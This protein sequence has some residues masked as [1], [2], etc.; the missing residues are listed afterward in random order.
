MSTPQ[1]T[2][3]QGRT[4]LVLAA[5]FFGVFV[6]GCA[7]LLVVGM[8]DLIATDLEVSIPT[9]GTLVTAYALG[10]AIGGPVLT[11]LTIKLARRAVLA[12][13]LVVFI[14]A[15][16]APVLITDYLVF[17]VA[18]GIDGAAQGLF[19]AVAFGV[20]TSIVPPERAGR[21]ISVIISGVAVSA[22][23][24]VPLGTAIGQTLGWRGSFIAIVVLSAIV[25]IITS[26]LVPSALSTGGGGVAGQAKYAFA[27]RVLAVLV[28]NL[29][30]FTSLYTAL[31]YIV[32][33]LQE[34][35]GI[36]GAMISVFLFAFGL[37]NA[38]GSFSGGWFADKNAGGT[39]IGGTAGTAVALLVLYFVGANPVLVALMML[40]WGLF[41]FIMVPALQLRVVSLAGP[42]G[43]LA[44]SLPAS[45]INVGV[46]LGPIIG[47]AALS[48]STSAPMIG[49]MIIALVGTVVAL[50]TSYLKP[51]VVA[52][53]T[54][55]AGV[56]PEPT[57][58]HA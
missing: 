55:S 8:L 54:G 1:A 14:L 43:E 35:T 7:E 49:G 19:V 17:L 46:A 6:M 39:L 38:V 40:V 56:V 28:L 53:A 50:A 44:Q 47:G 26:A 48:S 45:A 9:A 21:A 25:L 13:A 11:A 52:E 20:G 10:L 4:N 29:V 57:T 18:R 5:L 34:V 58:E 30:V 51:P 2:L 36:T 23:L 15:N 27:P 3:S 12:G 37:A 32:P 33:F 41:A 42:G 16:L 22:A 31:T 24:G